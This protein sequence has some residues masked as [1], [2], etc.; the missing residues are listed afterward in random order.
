MTINKIPLIQRVLTFASRDSV[1]L[2]RYSTVC[3]DWGET[4]SKYTNLSDEFDI[5]SDRTIVALKR[6]SNG[7]LDAVLV[8]SRLYD[9]LKLNDDN[10]SLITKIGLIIS[11][12]Y[13]RPEA[14]E[15]MKWLGLSQYQICYLA[16]WNGNKVIFDLTKEG[17]DFHHDENSLYDPDSEL[18]DSG[19]GETDIATATI[20]GGN[21]ELFLSYGIHARVWIDNGGGGLTEYDF[22]A[23]S[24]NREIVWRLLERDIAS[25]WQYRTYDTYEMFDDSIDE[26]ELAHCENINP[27]FHDTFLF[28][29]YLGQCN[30]LPYRE[31]DENDEWE[32]AKFEKL[33]EDYPNWYSVQTL[34]VFKKKHFYDII[35]KNIHRISPDID[36]PWKFLHNRALLYN[37]A[38]PEEIDFDWFRKLLIDNRR[39]VSLTHDLMN[40]PDKPFLEVLD[41]EV[42]DPD[43]DHDI[44]E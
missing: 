3:E 36:I 43:W 5:L 20:R 16:A 38:V 9:P 30:H 1:D 11:Q 22:A 40:S 31:P 12:N 21:M 39:D 4:A 2:Y 15:V 34:L 17:L 32:R 24:C 33:F 29:R 7:V 25:K 23:L 19:F 44:N 8:A 42:E 13:Q 37:P 6:G 10:K 41:T 27:K 26:G 35:E 28:V 18:S 14:V